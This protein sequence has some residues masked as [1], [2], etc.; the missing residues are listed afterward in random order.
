MDPRRGA[1]LPCGAAVGGLWPSVGAELNPPGDDFIAP[2][3]FCTVVHGI[4]SVGNAR[5]VSRVSLKALANSTRPV[6]KPSRAAKSRAR[7]SLLLLR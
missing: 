1:E 6:P 3:I 7:P 5:A 4:A 2:I